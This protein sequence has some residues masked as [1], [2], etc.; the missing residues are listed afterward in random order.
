[1]YGVN[2]ARCEAVTYGIRSRLKYPGFF[3]QLRDPAESATDPKF[4]RP[5]R[6]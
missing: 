6:D 5:A 2:D 1:M 3:S 4:A